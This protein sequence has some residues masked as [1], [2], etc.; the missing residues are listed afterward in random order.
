MK[1]RFNWKEKLQLQ[2]T[3]NLLFKIIILFL[4]ILAIINFTYA[5]FLT[6]ADLGIYLA[7]NIFNVQWNYIPYF[8]LTGL[9]L[10]VF[11]I[12]LLSFFNKK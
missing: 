12:F 2:D 5:V 8:S 9:A 7:N 6:I 3:R 1:L 4:V 11:M 10:Y